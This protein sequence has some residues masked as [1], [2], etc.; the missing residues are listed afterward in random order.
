M[1]RLI[2]GILLALFM[3]L[4]LVALSQDRERRQ[5]HCDGG[6]PIDIPGRIAA[7]TSV[8]DSTDS[9]PRERATALLQRALA[10][11][12][13]GRN[14]LALIDLDRAFQQSPEDGRIPLARAELQLSRGQYDSAV[15]D[16][17][18][19]IRLGQTDARSFHGRAQAHQR[20]SVGGASDQSIRDYSAAV[21]RE[22]DNVVMQVDLGDAWVYRVLSYLYVQD[23]DPEID[24]AWR[25]R[26]MRIYRSV[27]D[28]E[29]AIGLN[30]PDFDAYQ[31]APV[32]RREPHRRAMAAYDTALRVDPASVRALIGRGTALLLNGEPHPAID[33]F[34]AALR[35]EPANQRALTNRGTAWR[36][37]GEP[38]R[39]IADYD[40]VL[41]L[42]PGGIAA[43]WTSRGNALIDR[44]AF[45]QA[46]ESFDQA[47]RANPDYAPA[48]DNRGVAYLRM[49]QYER[50]IRDFTEAIRL[51]PWNP[52]AF[53]HRCLALAVARLK[54]AGLDCARS[55]D[56]RGNHPATH[57]VRALLHLLS[58]H[59][60][61]AIDQFDA[62]LK[63]QPTRAVALYGRGVAQR[64]NGNVRAA[65]ADIE[66]A[67]GIRPDIKAQMAKLG[68]K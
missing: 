34:T 29:H 62:A 59:V 30:R 35:L 42:G 31:R 8:I 18:E 63:R 17:S 12:A 38:D 6:A 21:E 32:L 9:T 51:R 1:A 33:A 5:R 66:S 27:R 28:H 55:E 22:P 23:F 64:R 40:A 53:R 37:I 24:T 39:A 43:V 60:S 46:V 45:V 19:A 3:A 13:G 41:R 36:D 68:V 50:A 2:G 47:I 65:T 4:P 11:A 7:C 49:H 67:V 57:E 52:S 16:F 20:L 48:F 25:Q 15:R 61:S 44:S 26:D 14:D 10:H 56:M 54:G 58:G